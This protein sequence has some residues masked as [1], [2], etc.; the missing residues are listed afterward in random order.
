MPYNFVDSQSPSPRHPRRS[1]IC[2]LFHCCSRLVRELACCHGLSFCM[3]QVFV[4]CMF[5]LLGLP[6]IYDEMVGLVVGCVINEVVCWNQDR[7][8]TS[9]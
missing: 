2:L 1:V 7:S 9:H 6:I 4:L 8:E 3:N 5:T